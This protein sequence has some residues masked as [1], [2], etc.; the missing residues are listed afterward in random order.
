[1][2]PKATEDT[3]TSLLKEE[4]DKRGVQVELIPSIETPVGLRKPDLLCKNGGTY[5]VEAKFAERDLI[6]A[7]AKVQ[8]DYLKHYKALGIKGRFR[9]S[10][11]RYPRSAY[12]FGYSEEPRT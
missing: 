5:P 3:I 6:Q 9:H 10:L 8:N 1:M 4:L 11:P 2:I 7:I 12:A